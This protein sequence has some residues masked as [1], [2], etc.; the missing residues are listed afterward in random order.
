[1]AYR[2]SQPRNKK[3]DT[4]SKE[5]NLIP[6]MNLFLTIIPFLMLFVAYSSLALLAVSLEAA[7]GGGDSGG[8][9]SG[10]GQTDLPMYQIIIYGANPD[11]AKINSFEIVDEGNKR[12]ISHI[13]QLNGRYDFNQLSFQLSQLK[14]RSPQVDD[15][16]VLPFG[17]VL[18]EVLL[19]TIDLCKE[20]KFIKVNYQEPQTKLIITMIELETGG[21][22]AA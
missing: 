1:M 14:S 12:V 13:K 5:P 19:Q 8:G 3:L 17:D 22:Y 15:I 11:P 20:N 2:P 16:K 10:G 21:I 6:V 4:S 9:G 7:G 18:F